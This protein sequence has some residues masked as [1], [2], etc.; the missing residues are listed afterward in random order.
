MNEPSATDP[1]T[2]PTDET[3]DVAPRDA[4]W[5]E[6]AREREEARRQAEVYEVGE[7]IAEAPYRLGAESWR[8]I[9]AGP[10]A[11]SRATPIS[12]PVSRDESYGVSQPVA[13]AGRRFARIESNRREWER[14]EKQAALAKV[15]T[16]NDPRRITLRGLL[17]VFTLASLV[18]AVGA[19]MP[20]GAFAGAAGGAALLTALA[21]RWLM[22]ESA[23]A[24]VAWWTLMVVYVVASFCA[25]VRF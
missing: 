9:V 14:R 2:Q 4:H 22:G 6:L 20:R 7:E 18:F 19:R 10:Q 15:G 12:D 16:W 21:S 17:F 1:P 11:G 5:T 24:K 13:S 25:L 3:Y 8:E 23:P